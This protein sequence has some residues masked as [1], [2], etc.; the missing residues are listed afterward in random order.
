MENGDNHEVK[1]IGIVAKDLKNCV[2]MCACVYIFM[3]SVP[4]PRCL[5]SGFD[6]LS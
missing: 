1:H 2:C 4:V 5:T 3:G 6:K